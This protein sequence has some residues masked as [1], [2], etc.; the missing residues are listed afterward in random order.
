MKATRSLA[1]RLHARLVRTDNG[2]LEWQGYRRPDGYG[3]IKAE[4]GRNA[5]LLTTHRAAWELEHGPIPEG[6]FVCHRCDNRPCCDVQH[7]FLGTPE[8][9]AADMVAKGRQAR[10]LAVGRGLIDDA[11]VL[12]IRERY[13]PRYE[14]I[15]S[16]CRWRS[17]ARELGQEYGITAR[18]VQEIAYRAKRAEVA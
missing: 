5:P 18:Y 1:D 11:T 3:R 4:G 14:L 10:G 12:A 15:P 2:C 8:D 7:L 13:R 6:M 9:N 16:G 17:N